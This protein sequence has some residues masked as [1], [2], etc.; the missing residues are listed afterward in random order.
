MAHISHHTIDCDCD[1]FL[2]ADETCLVYQHKDVKEIEEDVNNFFF[3]ISDWFV[4]K[5]L[6]IHF[7]EGKTKAYYL[8]QNI[9]IKTYSKYQASSHCD[10]SWMVI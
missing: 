1:L 10:I 2:Y 3:C 9:N 6:S 8:E 7:G 5:K 4:D